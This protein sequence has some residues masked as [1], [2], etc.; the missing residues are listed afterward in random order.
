MPKIVDHEARRR[1]VLDAASRLI[2]DG[3]LR[4]V[5]VRALASETGMAP[6]TLRH[7]VPRVADL[8]L[9]LVEHHAARVQ[10]RVA[11]VV[12][13]RPRPDAVEL[14][15]RCEEQVLPLDG[16]RRVEHD[17]AHA[18]AIGASAPHEWSW[19][20]QGQV[21][22]HRQ[23]VLALAD[24]SVPDRPGPL[25]AQQEQW[26]RHLHAY[27]DGLAHRARVAPSENVTG[28]LRTFLLLIR[29]ELATS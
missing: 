17:V 2:L 16:E 25:A 18:L 29:R 15:A 28:P 21:M 14:V 26:V 12:R 13:A 11:A 23:M 4:R 7:Y 27:V 10:E 20:W 9:L 6:S 22:F 3:G 1:D 19:A 24:Q 8:E 5:T